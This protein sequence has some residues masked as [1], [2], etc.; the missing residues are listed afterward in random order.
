MHLF[1]KFIHK[2]FIRLIAIASAS[3]RERATTHEHHQMDNTEIRLIRFFVAKLGDLL[4]SQ[5]KQKR[6]G[7]DCDSDHELLFAKFRLK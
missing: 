2:Y 4:Y 3:V 1:K 5:Q 6:P 7:A